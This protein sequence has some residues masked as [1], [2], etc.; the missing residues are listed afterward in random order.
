MFRKAATS[1]AVSIDTRDSDPTSLSSATIPSA[2]LKGLIHECNFGVWIPCDSRLRLR[3]TSSLSKREH[4]SLY[5]HVL[6][7]RWVVAASEIAIKH[8]PKH[9]GNGDV[10]VLSRLSRLPQGTEIARRK[11]AP[12]KAWRAA[13]SP[14]LQAASEK[15]LE[16]MKM[17]VTARRRRRLRNHTMN[18]V[19][20]VNQDSGK[21]LV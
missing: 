16:G 15:L 21:E 17:I 10:D 12:S 20:N 4:S 1:S 19:A 9:A 5:P 14:L 11:L 2:F 7:E 18:L 13:E 3:D 8:A 6:I